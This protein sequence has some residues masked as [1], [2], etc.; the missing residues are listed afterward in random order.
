VRAAFS[1]ACPAT[2]NPPNR[3]LW[4]SLLASAWGRYLVQTKIAEPSTVEAE[5]NRTIDAHAACYLWTGSASGLGDQHVMA[6]A[7]DSLMRPLP[8][9]SASMLG[10]QSAKHA[11]PA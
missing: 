6:A 9:S 11:H 4:R 8:L 3:K 2:H 5:T 1:A 10:A 7:T